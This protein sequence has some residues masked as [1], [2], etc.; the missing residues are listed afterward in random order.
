MS[1]AAI[2]IRN[3][4]KKNASGLAGSLR[5]SGQPP[6]TTHNGPWDLEA[7]SRRHGHNNEESYHKYVRP[8]TVTIE[9]NEYSESLEDEEGLEVLDEEGRKRRRWRKRRKLEEVTKQFN[10]LELVKKI[11]MFT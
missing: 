5:R 4:R 10:L 11:S 1:L 9:E 6:P 8:P 7:G 3:Q 2:A